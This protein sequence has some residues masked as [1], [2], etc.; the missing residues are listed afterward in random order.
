MSKLGDAISRTSAPSKASGASR[1]AAALAGKR[2]FKPIKVPVHGVEHDAAMTVI[3]SERHL[4]IEGETAKAMERR[5]FEQN[6]LNQSRFEL[7]EAIRVLAIAVVNSE[8][9]PRPFGSLAEW[10][11][12]VPEVISDLWLQYA[13]LRAQHDPQ[14]AE[15]SKLELDG[16]ADAVSKKNGPLLVFYGA[17]RL[18]RYLLT[19]AA[20]PASSSTSRSQP[21]AS[22]SD[23]SPSDSP[24]T[25]EMDDDS[26]T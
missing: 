14:L 1:L 8:E 20:R 3:G 10:G 23:T 25:P 2:P 13:E 21:G 7:D 6:V 18:A 12:L 15:L 17:R 5:G 9:D 24:S 11:E 4:D 16:I 26:G 22:S 19:L